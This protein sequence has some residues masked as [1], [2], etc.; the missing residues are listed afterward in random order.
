MP[1]IFAVRVECHGCDDFPWWAELL[2]SVVGVA[3]AFA[4]LYGLYRIVDRFLPAAP[5]QK[6]AAPPDEPEG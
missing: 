3:I 5:A 6:G 4:I 1:P 2:L